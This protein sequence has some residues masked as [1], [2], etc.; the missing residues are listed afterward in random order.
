[1]LWLV[2]IISFILY[3][4]YLTHS[5]NVNQTKEIE[6]KLECD[7]SGGWHSSGLLSRAFRATFC[8]WTKME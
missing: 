1:M 2:I 4:V 3:L 7:W 5:G 8:G 6:C